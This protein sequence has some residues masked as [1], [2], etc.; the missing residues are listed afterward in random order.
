MHMGV[1]QLRASATSYCPRHLLH[2]IDVLEEIRAIDVLEESK[3]RH[4][5]VV[6]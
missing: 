3:P 6:V 4:T 5:A 2:A 1:Y